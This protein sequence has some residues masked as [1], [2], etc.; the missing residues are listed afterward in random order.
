MKPLK[1]YRHRPPRAMVQL[2][3]NV[4][5]ISLTPF[6]CVRGTRQVMREKPD[7]SAAVDDET[8]PLHAPDIA[9]TIR[10]PQQ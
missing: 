5:M 7:P 1:K 3:Q 9:I 8:L 2:A 4:S 6:L 10:A